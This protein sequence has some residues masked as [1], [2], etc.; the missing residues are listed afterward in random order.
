[1]D[2]PSGVGIV[3]D[4]PLIDDA[5]PVFVVKLITGAVEAAA[6][7]VKA[8]LLRRGQGIVGRILGAQLQGNRA[9]DIYA[10][11]RRVERVG[12]SIPTSAR[13]PALIVSTLQRPPL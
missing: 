4:E 8:Q 2:F 5:Q 6:A 11:F 10:V 7:K 3:A 9:R 1:M 13:L 12:G